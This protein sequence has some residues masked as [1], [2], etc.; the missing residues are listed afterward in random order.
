MNEELQNA[1]QQLISKSLDGIDTTTVFLNDQLPIYVQQ[2]LLWYGFY[3]FI[4]FLLTITFTCVAIKCIKTSLAAPWEYED[5]R[6]ENG[7]C[8]IIAF[9]S[10][11]IASTT[12]NLTWLQIW[13]APKVWLVEYARSLT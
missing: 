6:M 8:A 13:I 10:I 11:I 4:L 2:L 7:G 1:V 9:V 5:F 12:M 3:Y